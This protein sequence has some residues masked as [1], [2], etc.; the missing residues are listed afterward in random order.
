MPAVPQPPSSRT[1]TESETFGRIHRMVAWL[2]EKKGGFFI[3]RLIMQ[4]GINL[5]SFAA[6]S[7]DDPKVLS[8]M[9][10]MLDVMLTAEEREALLRVLR[11]GASESRA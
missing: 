1:G 10:P 3:S 4:L 5:R 6:G 11:E 9:W 2:D 8:K 7:K